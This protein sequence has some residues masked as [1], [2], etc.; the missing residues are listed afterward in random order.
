M[1]SYVCSEVEHLFQYPPCS[2]ESE[3]ISLDA[4]LRMD[5]I[6]ALGSWD[7]VVEGLHSSNEVPPTLKDLYTPKQTKRSRGKPQAQYP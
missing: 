2:T 3:I 1:A 7:V 6:L 5:G 4:G